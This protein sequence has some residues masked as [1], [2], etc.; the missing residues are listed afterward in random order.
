ML[1]PDCGAQQARPVGRI[2]Q[3]DRIRPRLESAFEE[4]LRVSHEVTAA[5]W[6]NRPFADRLKEWTA[7]R[8]EYGR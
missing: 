3:G 1:F 2:S 4:Y 7:R 8:L 5:Q 6:A